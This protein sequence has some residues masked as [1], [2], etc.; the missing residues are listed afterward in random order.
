MWVTPGVQIYLGHL[1]LE[2]ELIVGLVERERVSPYPE[3]VEARFDAGLRAVSAGLAAEWPRE[4]GTLFIRAR[5]VVPTDG[6]LT[7]YGYL[8]V[9]E[10]GATWGL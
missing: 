7:F 8:P 3:Q 9:L 4:T 10:I 1:R 5:A 6:L 2:L